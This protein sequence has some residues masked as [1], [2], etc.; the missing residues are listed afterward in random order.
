MIRRRAKMFPSRCVCRGRTDPASRSCE[1]LKVAAAS[2][3]QVS[4]REVTNVQQTTIDTS[5]YRKNLRPVVYVT[6]DVAGE[7]ESPVY[8][9]LKMS[10]AIGKIQLPDGYQRAASTPAR[11]CPRAPIATR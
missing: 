4:L 10:E 1:N 6:G 8:A 11:H 5:V 2:G 7:I 3:E 9:I